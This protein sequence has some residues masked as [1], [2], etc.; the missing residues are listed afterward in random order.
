M[1][2]AKSVRIQCPDSYNREAEKNEISEKKNI[3]SANFN[4]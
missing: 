3:L 2:I 4:F 1:D